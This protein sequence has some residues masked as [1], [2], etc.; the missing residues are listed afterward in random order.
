MSYHKVTWHENTATLSPALKIGKKKTT[1]D[2]WQCWISQT[3]EKEIMVRISA[4]WKFYYFIYCLGREFQRIKN[5][6]LSYYLDKN[7]LFLHPNLWLYWFRSN[8]WSLVTKMKKSNIKHLFKLFQVCFHKQ[9]NFI[10]YRFIVA[11]V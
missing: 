3:F 8:I 11:I 5:T 2:I 6:P 10:N 9:L 7:D 1:D 4:S